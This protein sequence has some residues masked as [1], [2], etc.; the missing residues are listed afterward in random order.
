[1]GKFRVA[2]LGEV[3]NVELRARAL[4]E[5]GNLPDLTNCSNAFNTSNKM[6]VHGEVANCVPV[7][8]PVMAKCYVWCKT[9]ERV[10]PNVIRGD[11]DKTFLQRDPPAEPFGARYVL[12]GVAAGAGTFP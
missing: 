4:H 6:A 10:I 5:A 9:S 7:L 3:E 12:P 11:P 2:V 8:T 1:M